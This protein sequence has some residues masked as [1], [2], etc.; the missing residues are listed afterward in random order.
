MASCDGEEGEEEKVDEGKD[1]GDKG[2]E[3]GDGDKGEVD[4]RTLE[5]GSSGSPGMGT[6]IHSFSL[7]CGLLMTLSQQWQP[8]S[9]R[10]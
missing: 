1:E 2:G 3:E 7:K 8:T 4:G 5:G 10:I 9:L 6:P